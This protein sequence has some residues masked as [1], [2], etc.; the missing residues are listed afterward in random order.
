MPNL[1]GIYYILRLAKGNIDLV[2]IG[3]SG[4]IQQ[5]GTFKGQ[6]LRDRINNKCNGQR[7][8]DFFE[9]KCREENIDALDIYWFVTFEGRNRD[10]PAYVEALL[11][12]NFFELH[13]HLPQWNKCF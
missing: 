9:V 1:K 12:Q 4:A 5:E 7:R 8:E 2:Y 3:K 13:G 10:L 11:V 6:S